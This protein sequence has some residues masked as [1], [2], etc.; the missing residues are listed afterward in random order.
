VDEPPNLEWLQT[1][2][3]FAWLYTPEGT[4]WT[5]S[6]AGQAWLESESGERFVE[7][8]F[9]AGWDDYFSGRMRRG[10]VPASWMTPETAPQIGSRVRIREDQE[11]IGGTR[12]TA[13]ELAIVSELRF[14]PV[15]I[16]S[17]L[18]RTI[19]GRRIRTFDIGM[20]DRA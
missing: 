14:A 20:I 10:V 19:D 12:I 9:Q 18:L 6:S 7:R 2:E 13:G 17:A 3:G 1:D 5:H 11:T 4:K 8:V 15:G 16:V